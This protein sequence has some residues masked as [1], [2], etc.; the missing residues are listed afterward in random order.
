MFKEK[1]CWGEVRV[2]Y[3]WYIIIVTFIIN[4]IIGIDSVIV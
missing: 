1:C 3:R 4:S 2:L